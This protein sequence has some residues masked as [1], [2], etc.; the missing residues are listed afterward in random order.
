MLSAHELQGLWQKTEIPSETGVTAVCAT[1]VVIDGTD[2]VV[3]RDYLGR[4]HLLV[5]IVAGETLQVNLRS[6]GIRA[7][8]PRELLHGGANRFFLDV[9]C[10][11]QE[12]GDVF[13]RLAEELV[14]EAARPGAGAAL[15]CANALEG[16]RSLFG[17]GAQSFGREQ[18][19][20]LIGELRMLRRLLGVSPAA[21]ASWTGP[22]GGVHDF[23]RGS[24][25]IEVKA[26][27]RTHGLFHSI[28]GIDQLEAPAGGRLGFL[29]VRLE[30]VPGGS[31]SLT[32]LVTEIRTS[33]VVATALNRLLEEAGFVEGASPELE[34]ESFEIREERF[35]EVG[36]DFPRIVG[37]SLAGGRLP[38]GVLGLGYEIDLTGRPPTPLDAA[39][40]ERWIT[41]FACLP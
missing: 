36:P 40:T 26:T 4:R 6:A 12:L 5:P 18:A 27:V 32:A 9:Y 22:L 29:S 17:S 38:A 1:G 37:S 35:Y 31:V 20:G 24:Q 10:T 11:R 23:R 13:A 16:W 19:I 34:D 7:S 15:R 28:S 39:A 21:L 2:V 33:G 8:A 3:G 41:S 25:A 14:C 30:A